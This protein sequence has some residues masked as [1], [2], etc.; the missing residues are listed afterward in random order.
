MSISNVKFLALFPCLVVTLNS[1]AGDIKHL[2]EIDGGAIERW[3]SHSSGSTRSL[4]TESR[5]LE[6]Q[7]NFEFNSHKVT[8]DDRLQIERLARIIK[9][10][11]RQEQRFTIEGHTDRKG[12]HEYNLALSTR[13]ANEVKSILVQ[14]G[15]ENARLSAIG[16]SFNELAN[17]EQPFSAENR[18]VKVILSGN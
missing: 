12:S 15:I 16:K 14:E 2:R 1:N 6:F 5:A 13:R 9:T 10:K 11:S 18:R 17:R 4:S 8:N 3:L 7:V